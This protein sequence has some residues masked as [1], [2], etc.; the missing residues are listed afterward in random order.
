MSD[1]MTMVEDRNKILKTNILI[2]AILKIIGLG[3]SLL[4]VPVTI[5]YLDSE[6]YG[7]WMTM[8]SV[9]FW[10]GGFDIG[11]GNGMR[12]YL[13]EAISKQNYAL[14]RKYISTTFLLLSIIALL[15][16][17]IGFVAISQMN[18]CEFFNTQSVENVDLRS[19][20]FIAVGFTLVNFVVKNIGFIYVAMQKY[21]VNDFLNVSANVISLGI[22]FVLTKVTSGNLLYVV[23][24]YTSTSCLAFV[25]A[26]IPLF[27]KHPELKPS[28][29]FFD[30]N[31]SREIIGKG[32]G[33][34]VIQITS[35]IV[36]F[37]AAN[38]FITQYCGPESVT[39][40]NI[41]YKYFNLEIIGY[42]IILAPMWN[43]YTD[44]YVKGDMLWVEKTFK[45]ALNFWVLSVAAGI[46]MLL[47]CR[48]FYELWIGDKVQ[49]PLSVSVCTFIYVCMF[50]INN[51]ATYLIN[52]FNKI[53]V[54]IIT[55]LF[56]TILYVLV[57]PIFGR[58]QGI[59]G[60][61]LAMAASYFMMAVI[62]LYQCRLLIKKKANGIWNK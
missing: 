3:T 4:I 8:T 34:F 7:I 16:L 45:R 17:L 59:E 60:I 53:R 21:A 11:L 6:V 9:L 36:L 44:A 47:C 12:N 33:F 54:Q 48:F 42:T 49:I 55:S 14:G 51:C 35:C 18:F 19:A 13:T 38:I 41:A 32:I 37:G 56:F 10:I 62:H 43:A 26:A 57:V 31:L 15:L 28:I 30:K 27:R 25:L 22:I 5:K 20:M 58:K 39:T 23:L 29:K 50:N 1:C 61:V 52:G 46:L 2:S 24:A 40:Y